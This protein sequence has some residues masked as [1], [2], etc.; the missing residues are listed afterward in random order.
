MGIKIQSGHV[1]SVGSPHKD[2]SVDCSL[3][4]YQIKVHR[5][6]ADSLSEGDDVAVAGEVK[7]SVL[8]ALAINNF[9]KDKLAQ[10]DCTNYILF[11]VLGCF[12]F[13]LFAILSLLE[14]DGNVIVTSAED[15]A[16][17]GGLVLAILALRRTIHVVRAGSWV[18]YAEH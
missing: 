6:L 3:G 4:N 5:D 1:T 13:I 8:Q 17:L 9:K 14:T 12:V 18:K 16:S 10:I 11:M 7:N 15:V 2:G